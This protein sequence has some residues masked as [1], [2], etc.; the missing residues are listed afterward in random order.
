MA[1]FFAQR[2]FRKRSDP[3]E[4]MGNRCSD[5]EQSYGSICP[6]AFSRPVYLKWA[7]F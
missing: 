7:V 3:P 1:R 4:R 5:A 6:V 2:T